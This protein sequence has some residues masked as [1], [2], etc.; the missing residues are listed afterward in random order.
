MGLSLQD[1]RSCISLAFWQS[2]SEP[3]PREH[4]YAC[5]GMHAVLQLYCTAYRSWQICT[6][7]CQVLLLIDSASVVSMKDRSGMEMP[8]TTI[9]ARWGCCVL[10]PKSSP[11]AQTMPSAVIDKHNCTTC[12]IAQRS[13]L[14][15]KWKLIICCCQSCSSMEL[16]Q[17]CTPS[18][19]QQQQRT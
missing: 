10:L 7:Q 3:L 4:T 8:A 19:S 18:I 17:Q 6:T 15:Q 9:S 14:G 16:R 12:N 13:K 2:C 1:Q 5:F 11:A